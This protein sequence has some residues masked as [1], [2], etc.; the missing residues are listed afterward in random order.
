MLLRFWGKLRACPTLCPLILT[1]VRGGKLTTWFWVQLHIRIPWGNFLLRYRH[2]DPVSGHS[3]VVGRTQ[4]GV[5]RL[6]GCR[7]ENHVQE[8]QGSVLQGAA[9]RGLCS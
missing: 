1:A 4:M 5:R 2:P 9:R 7:D 8:G 3:D 6:S